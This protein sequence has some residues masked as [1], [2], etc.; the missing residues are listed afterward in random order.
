MPFDCPLSIEDLG[1]TPLNLIQQARLQFCLDLEGDRWNQA[2]EMLAGPDGLCAVG[3]AL[4]FCN[5]LH[6]AMAEDGEDCCFSSLLTPLDLSYD[7]WNLMIDWN[8][9]E[10]FSFP[11]IASLLRGRWGLG[12]C[13]M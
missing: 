7:D 4:A 12:D 3:A 11:A 6:E 10:G 2:R 8:D 9:W 1:P 5:T 13:R